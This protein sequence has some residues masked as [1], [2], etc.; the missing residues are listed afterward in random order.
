VL[1]ELSNV[2]RIWASGTCVVNENRFYSQ[3]TVEF[4]NFKFR[5]LFFKIVPTHFKMISRTFQT[6]DISFFWG[7]ISYPISRPKGWYNILSYITAKIWK[8]IYILYPFQFYFS[9]KNM[10]FVLSIFILKIS[11]I[12]LSLTHHAEGRVDPVDLALKNRN[13][14]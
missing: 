1:S 3:L 6:P 11:N 2:D 12:Q 10:K 13:W 5:E 4:P 8:K 7:Y 9:I 14:F